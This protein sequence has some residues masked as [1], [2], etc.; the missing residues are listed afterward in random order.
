MEES[1]EVTDDDKESDSDFMDDMA[2]LVYFE[3]LDQKYKGNNIDFVG[4]IQGLSKEKQEYLKNLDYFSD[5]ED[6][7]KD[8][9]KPNKFLA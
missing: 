8:V 4:K 9:R 6:N 5:E 2:K 1:K 7:Q 3:D